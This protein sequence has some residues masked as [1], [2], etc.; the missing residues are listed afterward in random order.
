MKRF[1]TFVIGFALL[2]AVGCGG[3]GDDAAVPPSGG[4]VAPGLMG[5]ATSVAI[6]E[7]P[8]FSLDTS[9]YPA[10]STFVV[11]GNAGLVNPAEGGAYGPLE[12]KWGVDVVIQAKDYDPCLAEFAN[13]QCDA[14]CIT[15][16]DS[17]NPAMG[18][19][20]TGILPNSNSVGSDKVIA[21]GVDDVEGLKTVTTHGLEKSVS[22][23]SWYREL[24]A[25]GKN[26]A[27]YKYVNLDPG[28][29]ATALQNTSG[30]VKAIC[31]WHPFALQTIKNA[32]GA[33][34]VMDSSLIPLE[35]IDQV[36][37]GNDSLAKP[38]GE[39]FAACLCDIYFTVCG[40]LWADDQKVQDTTRLALKEDFAPSFDLNDMKI[41]LKDSKF[42][43]TAAEGIALYKNPE[44][45]KLTEATVIPT[46]QKI[47]ILE[48]G[49][50][51]TIGY[52]GE[53]GKQLTFSTKYM[54]MTT[55]K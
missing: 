46:C 24:E 8:V 28:A 35:I 13:A 18:R 27:D 47:G 54:D 39:A 17:L 23:Y 45:R 52:D 6:G 44:F 9:E 48:A 7:L 20:C 3:G 55:T 32:P 38:G 50:K 29:A 11:A 34:T 15:V 37:I 36:V 21:V 42:Y 4:D 51:P 53:E 41:I 2:F 26:P 25:S 1:A 19:P 16:I 40:N 12:I 5:E 30:E 43:R 49:K 10:W 22:H 14:A 33:K 31:V